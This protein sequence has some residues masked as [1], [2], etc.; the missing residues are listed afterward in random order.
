[1]PQ[2]IRGKRRRKDKQFDSRLNKLIAKRNT[3]AESLDI[4]GSLIAA[5]TP[6]EALAGNVE[7]AEA[8]LMNWQREL[9]GI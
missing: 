3:I 8:L 9:L 5:R 7:G 2:R 6:L 4:D 1:M